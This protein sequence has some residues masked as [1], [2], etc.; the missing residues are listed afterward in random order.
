LV[1]VDLNKPYTVTKDNILYKCKWSPFE[2]YTF[3]A[4]IDSTIVSGH[5]VYHNN[6]FNESK[7]GERLKFIR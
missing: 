1:L 2:Q 6:V 5:L 3:N 4:S 7:M